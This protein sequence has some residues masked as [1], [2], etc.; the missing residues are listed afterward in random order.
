MCLLHIRCSNDD[1]PQ[2]PES[3]PLLTIYERRFMDAIVVAHSSSKPPIISS[4]SL[5]MCERY[6]IDCNCRVELRCDRHVRTHMAVAHH[7]EQTHTHSLHS[8]RH[9]TTQSA[10][11]VTLQ[12]SRG[13][14]GIARTAYS[15]LSRAKCEPASAG[16]VLTTHARAAH[17]RCIYR[18]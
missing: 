3:L 12:T 16:V 9:A 13:H 7:L 17:N 15:P 14:C 2:I 1:L 11:E 10:Q 6:Q 4:Q 8:H 5:M 18:S